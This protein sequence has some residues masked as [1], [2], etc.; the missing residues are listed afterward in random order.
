MIKFILTRIGLIIP[1]FI[2][3]TL[4]T[5]MLIR[6]VP[7][8]PIE[9]LVGE[10]GI[11][12]D[13]HAELR[14]DL[15]L[16]KPML[17]QYVIYI[18][19]LLQGD[20]GKS[21]VTKTPV[22]EEFLTLFPATIELSLCAMMIAIAIGIPIGILAAAKRGTFYDYATMGLSLTGYSMPVFWWALILILTFSV[23]LGWTP[24]SG[25]I[26]VLYYVE[27]VTGFMLIDTLLSD[28]K[29]A[30]YIRTQAPYSACY[31]LRH[32]PAGG[33]CQNDPFVHAGSPGRRLYSHRESQGS[34]NLAYRLGPCTS[35]CA[36]TRINSDR[37]G[38][39]NLVC[40]C[41]FN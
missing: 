9:L 25:R 18:K 31:R 14:A 5:F 39:G 11:D 28:E 34:A 23:T 24:V 33:D 30:V 29:G 21:I 3:V 16:D 6:L 19:N 37:F 22:I 35:K 40:R 20:F 32:H 38:G 12:P 17:E 2:G 15:G 27:P 4:V 13:R 36:D 8:D 7:G 1:T 26:S 10:R 41:H